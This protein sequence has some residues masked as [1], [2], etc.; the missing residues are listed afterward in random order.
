MNKPLMRAE[1]MKYGDSQKDLAN[2]LGI[3]LS[4]LNLKI[5]G[6]ADFRQAEILFIKDRYKL[7][8]EEIDAIF[9]TKEYPKKIQNIFL[10]ERKRGEENG[11]S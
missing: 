1:M 3:S 7:K 2:A 8:P 10:R 9:F 11:R 6:G 5:N 4:R